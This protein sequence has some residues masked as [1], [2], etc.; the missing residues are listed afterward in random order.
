[1]FYKLYENYKIMCFYITYFAFTCYT[2]FSGFISKDLI[3]YCLIY[4]LFYFM[5]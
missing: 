4:F 5:L 2:F 3:N 1:M